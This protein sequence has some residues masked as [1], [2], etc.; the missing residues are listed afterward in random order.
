ML[1]V[2]CLGVCVERNKDRNTASSSIRDFSL[3]AL[4]LEEDSQVEGFCASTGA[5][6]YS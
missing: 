2:L 6:E 1:R 3:H 5:Q 4:L